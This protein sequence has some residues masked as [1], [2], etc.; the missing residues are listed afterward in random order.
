MRRATGARID[1]EGLGVRTKEGVVFSGV[2]LAA[3]PGSLT[4]FHADSGGGRTSL[5]L[6]LAGRMRPTEGTLAVDGYELPKKARK[7]RGVAALALCDGVNDLED[8]LRVAEHLNERLLLRFRPAPRSVTGPALAAAGLGDLDTSRMVNDLSMAEKRR[9]GVALALLDEPRLIVVDDADT[10]LGRDQ[11]R[12]FFKQL[13]DV[14]DTG[15]TVVAACA[16]PE[17]A[18]GLADVVAL[19]GDEQ[20]PAGRHAR[21][22]ASSPAPE[23]VSDK[24]NA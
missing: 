23:D 7:V 2:D 20:G 10:G 5:L 13:R 18:E 8:R 3:A 9:L 11:Q 1:A 17:A 24:E 21:A 16:D 19:T 6:T 15:P 14:A 12:E 4:V 22:L